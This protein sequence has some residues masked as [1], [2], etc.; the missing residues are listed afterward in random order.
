MSSSTAEPAP[1]KSRDASSILA[2]FA[3]GRLLTAASHGPRSA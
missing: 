1:H 2:A 3:N